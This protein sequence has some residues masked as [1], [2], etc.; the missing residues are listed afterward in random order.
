MEVLGVGPSRIV[1]DAKAFLLE[2]R[3]EEGEISESEAT[4]RL[5]AWARD[6]T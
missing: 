2:I 4:E 6:R 1:G 3:L 5:R